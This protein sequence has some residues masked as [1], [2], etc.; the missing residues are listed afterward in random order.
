MTYMGGMMF[1]NQNKQSSF[2]NALTSLCILTEYWNVGRVPFWNTLEKVNISSL[3]N[4]FNSPVTAGTVLFTWGSLHA[5]FGFPNPFW[6]CSNSIS[7]VL[8]TSSVS[9]FIFLYVSFLCLNFGSSSLLI[10]VHPSH[11]SLTSCSG[12]RRS[13]ET[14]QQIWTLLSTTVPH[15]TLPSRSLLSWYPGLWTWVVRH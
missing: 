5:G 4:Y 8:P 1:P 15:G 14:R 7:I 6:E 2:W 13:L 12:R 3:H 11:T 9:V 10:Y